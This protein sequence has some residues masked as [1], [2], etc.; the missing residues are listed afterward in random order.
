MKWD[1]EK[2]FSANLWTNDL[3][4]ASSD[5]YFVHQTFKK[6]SVGLKLYLVG[7]EFKNVNLTFHLC[8]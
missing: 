4:K 3:Y 8:I 5:Y 7:A 6:H 2:F 1:V